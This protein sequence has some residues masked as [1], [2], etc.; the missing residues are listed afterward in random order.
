V[1]GVVE[2]REAV[3]RTA[4]QCQETCQAIYSVH[5]TQ[6]QQVDPSL[7][8]CRN[9]CHFFSRIQSHPE[10]RELNDSHQNCDNNCG[11]VY[12]SG[13]EEVPA[14]RAGC[15]AY[16]DA[17]TIKEF[18]SIEEDPFANLFSSMDNI[19]GSRPMQHLLGRRPE[20]IERPRVLSSMWGRKD[21]DF[22]EPFEINMVNGDGLFG[23]LHSQMSSMLQNMPT[24]MEMGSWN[25]FSQLRSG[26]QMTVIK[27]GPGFHEEKHYNI[28]PDGKL[29]QVLQQLKSDALDH[30]NPMDTEMHEDDVEL[31]DP[32]IGVEI[33]A[34]KEVEKIM[35]EI[36]NDV[37]INDIEKS[38]NKKKMEDLEDFREFF[39]E[40]VLGM[41]DREGRNNGFEIAGN[42]RRGMSGPHRISIT[43]SGENTKWSDW[44]ACI[45]E[46]VG[47]PRWLTAATISLGIV[48][49]IWL[50]LVIPAAAPKQKVKQAAIVIAQTITP[51]AAAK[52]KEAEASASAAKAKELEANGQIDPLAVAFTV[53]LPPHYEEVTASASPEPVAEDVNTEVAEAVNT[54]VAAAAVTLEPVHGEDKTKESTA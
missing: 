44:V 29:T 8:A 17:M 46:K 34:K 50:C 52:A 9:G 14:C 13:N 53:D 42:Y 25:P 21:D 19:F 45:H 22:F 51:T 1:V 16:A 49:S 18:P 23:R 3:D 12:T 30:K 26:G 4:S 32:E 39:E 31:I 43:C 41:E 5:T 11:E 15:R 47:V 28:G 10:P 54:E 48:F 35:K 24:Q 27:A 20:R 33:D 38:D 40:N 36:D 2:S 37:F 6:F 7:A